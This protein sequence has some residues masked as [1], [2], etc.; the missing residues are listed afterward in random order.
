MSVYAHIAFHD[1]SL[2]TVWGPCS[3]GTKFIC[4]CPQCEHANKL[5]ADGKDWET[6]YEAARL[7]DFDR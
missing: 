5:E 2:G 6:E 1:G 7:R 3:D 4:E